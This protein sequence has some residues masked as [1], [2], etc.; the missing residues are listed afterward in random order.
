MLEDQLKLLDHQLASKALE[1]LLQLLLEVHEQE[2]LQL[3]I[4]NLLS[5][6]LLDRVPVVH[7]LDMFLSTLIP[8][9]L[10]LNS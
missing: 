2:E 8:Q 3:S 10:H 9:C 5:L 4:I 7:L 6:Y 1:A